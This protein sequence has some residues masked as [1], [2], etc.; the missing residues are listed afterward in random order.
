MSKRLYTKVSKTFWCT[1]E[2]N[3]EPAK[4]PAVKIW[5]EGPDE[6]YWL[7][8][9]FEGGILLP[10]HPKGKKRALTILLTG[11]PGTGKSTLAL[12]LCHRWTNTLWM[13]QIN[14]KIV[15]RENVSLSSL[16][17]TSETEEEWAIQKAISLGWNIPHVL[18]NGE[19]ILQSMPKIWQTTDFQEF[20]QDEGDFSGIEGF[21]EAS[22]AL[23]APKAKVTPLM[24]ALK[25]K[26]K[27][28]G[29]KS[30]IKDMGP[31]ILVIDSLNTI[32]TSKRPK[33]FNRFMNL[34]N[35]GPRIILIIVEASSS[36]G[37]DFWN[38][39]ADIVIRLDKRTISE[40]LVRTIEIKKARYQSHVWGEHQLKIYPETFPDDMSNQEKRRA[41]PYRKQ[42][43]IFI[44]PSIHY[45]LSAYKHSK[46]QAVRRPFK[47]PIPSLNEIFKEGFPRGRCTGFMGIRGGHKSHLGYLSILSRVIPVRSNEAGLI[48][49]LRD[50]E[51]MAR[52]TLEGILKQETDYSGTLND[53]EE[54]D[55]IEILYFPPGYV[56]PEEFF[57]RVFMSVQRLKNSNEDVTVLFNSLD[58]LSSRFP[59]CARQQIF[60]PGLIE[61][62]SAE[63]VTSFF[64]A[65]EEPGQPQEQYGLLSVA[66]ALIS[67]TR[68]EYKKNDYLSFVRNH[69]GTRTDDPNYRIVEEELPASEQVVTMRI[70]RF[71]GGQAAGAGGLL[72]LI[73]KDTLKS[74]LYKTEGLVF[75][76]FS[77]DSKHLEAKAEE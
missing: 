75:V 1:S 49:S 63:N 55:K 45:Y 56:T 19:N 22:V 16:Y 65:V 66:D 2:G 64:I 67:F 74:K 69:L 5:E 6:V 42:G 7:D 58:Q 46:P 26:W 3:Y 20:L 14:K 34:V 77:S 76:P 61:T 52:K 73:H 15:E 28:A 41:H 47:M 39:I 18:H 31:N 17:V 68:V 36:T 27:K 54:N 40:Y 24:K 30:S 48:I 43:G 70:V 10:E 32:E 33:I 57:H 9:L 12:E 72:E 53:L 29:I 21:L 35:Y 51:S 62:L 71:A 23:F 37:S 60:V 44:Y 8:K 38:Y 13:K 4:I 11:P 50:D 59:L 25:T